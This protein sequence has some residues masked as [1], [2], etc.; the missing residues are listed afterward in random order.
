MP[1]NA[2]SQVRARI[3]QTAIDIRAAAEAMV[4]GDKEAFKRASSDLTDAISIGKSEILT[5][6]DDQIA[7]AE[8]PG[9]ELA[10]EAA[11]PALKAAKEGSITASIRAHATRCAQRHVLQ[12]GA[13]GWAFS[14]IF[15]PSY[16]QGASEGWLVDPYLALRFQRRNLSEFVMALLDGAKLKVLHIVTREKN[17]LPEV[18][19]QEFYKRLDIDAYEKKGMRVDMTVDETIHDRFFI[20]DNGCVFKL[21]RGLDIYKPATGLA[22]RDPVLRQVR[23]CEIDVF[24]PEPAQRKGTT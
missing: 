16:L 22:A 14:R 17:D 20:L 3:E 23:A 21:G 11:L 18:T 5:L 9:T 13:K 1:E 6:M 24:L 19:T 4:A 7:D 2:L 8:G 10:I 12:N 15:E